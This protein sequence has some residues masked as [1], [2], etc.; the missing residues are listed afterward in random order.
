VCLDLTGR[1]AAVVGG[2]AG[3]G[4]AIARA[5]A[6]RGADVVVVGR[7]FRDQGTRGIEFR[8]ADLSLLREASRVGKELPA[9]TLDLVVMTTGIM[10]APKRQ[11]TAEG[12]ERDMA[13]SYLSRLVI[14][15]ELASRLKKRESNGIRP[16]V[17]IMGFPGKGNAGSAADLNAEKSYSAMA[18][19]MNTVAGNEMLVLES[20]K[21]YPEVDFFGLNPGLVPTSIRGNLLGEAARS[22]ASPSG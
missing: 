2:T 16:R 1:K 7:T 6:A 9:E 11:E 15:R 4:R 22:T 21:R 3:I 5:L 17:F 18:V 10:A 12:I 14:V 19:H 13:V 20:T 8:S